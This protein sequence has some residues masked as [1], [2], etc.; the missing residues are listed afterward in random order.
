MPYF[1]NSFRQPFDC[2][3]DFLD[4]LNGNE[5]NWK[6]NHSVRIVSMIAMLIEVHEGT[7]RQLSVFDP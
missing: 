2:R 5:T 6:T 3:R 4:Q 7:L 1:N